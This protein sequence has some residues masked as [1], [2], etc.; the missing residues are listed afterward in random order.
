VNRL[1]SQLYEALKMNQQQQHHLAYQQRQSASPATTQPPEQIPAASATATAASTP[2]LSAESHFLELV[3][4][5]TTA[6]S[7]A[8][9]DLPDHV[10][11][12]KSELEEARRRLARSRSEEAD[13]R[14]RRYLEDHMLED[15]Q[16]WMHVLQRVFWPNDKEAITAGYPLGLAHFTTPRYKSVL[17]QP[18]GKND[19]QLL[20]QMVPDAIRRAAEAA[21]ALNI[22]KVDD[23]VETVEHF[24][25][26]SWCHVTLQLLRAPMTTNGLR[27][28][29]ESGR[30]MRFADERILKLL[31]HISTKAATWKAKARKAIASRSLDLSKLTELVLEGN[32]I[33]VNSRI[34][35]VLKE[36]LKRH[37]QQDQ[38]NRRTST[39]HAE[40]SAT[41]STRRSAAI[42]NRAISYT[43]FISL[44]VN[45]PDSSDD[46]SA[47][48]TAD[49][50]TV[51]ATAS[52]S[53]EDFPASS[54][55]AMPKALWPMNFTFTPLQK[56][57]IKS[58]LTAVYPP[59]NASGAA[60]VAT[61]TSAI[62]STALLSR[63]S[64][65]SSA[66]ASQ[67]SVGSKTVSGPLAQALQ[68]S[69]SQGFGPSS[70][71]YVTTKAVQN[72]AAR[73]TAQAAGQHHARAHEP[74]LLKISRDSGSSA[75]SAVGAKRT[76]D[77]SA[78]F[79][80]SESSQ[81]SA[82]ASSSSSSSNEP[83][84]KKM[85]TTEPEDSSSNS[86]E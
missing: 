62:S 64:S 33:P 9:A 32:A 56:G 60:P 50:A 18:V 71:T 85:R 73:A 54:L 40:D 46:E 7:A 72:A 25:W 57:N 44:P 31:Q 84:A 45:A 34:K 13:S 19:D 2:A 28:I 26:M 3:S 83:T 37:Q 55:A 52:V 76:I 41:L 8:S 58:L 17:F 11:R 14:N 79:V 59:A 10:K 20:K 12:I 23:V 38:S 15:C 53:Y 68:S 47:S 86:M 29:L 5:S 49:P 36:Q 48:T 78:N 69:K 74:L 21:V 63:Q 65:A 51:S 30:P 80:A 35:V 82:S 43:G 67:S 61:Q 22:D 27:R 1:E 81:G 77:L 39:D 66:S 6:S 42:S 4:S 75:E 70:G 24:R 16:D